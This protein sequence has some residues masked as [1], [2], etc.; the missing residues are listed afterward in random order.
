M[1]HSEKDVPPSITLSNRER[2][3]RESNH[4]RVPD[5]AMFELDESTNLLG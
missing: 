2:E 1:A 3:T 5:S 4:E